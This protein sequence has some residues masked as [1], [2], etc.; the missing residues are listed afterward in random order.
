MEPTIQRFVLRHSW[1]ETL[2]LCALT[3]GSL[4]LYY[5]SLDVPKNIFNQAILGKGIAFPTEVAGLE[6]SQIG[7]LFLLCTWFLVLVVLNGGIKQYINT[8]KGRLGER[9]L[10]RM[11]YEL[12][13]RIMR[14]PLPHFRKVSSGELIPMVTAE[15]EPL[16]GYMGDAFAQPLIQAGTLLTIVTFLF[17]QN[18]IM[19]LAAISLYPV[20]GYIIPKLQR[21][22]NLLGK[23]RVR[24]VRKV[25]E[26]I[27][28]AVAGI[29]EIRGHGAVA[30]ERA[31]FSDRLGLIF[32]IRFEIYQRKSLAK[33]LNNFLNQMAPLLFYSIGGYLVITGDL[34]AGA[35]AAALTAHKDMSSPWKELLDYY[36]QYQ[37]T[38]IKF[39]QVVEQFRPERMVEEE[40]QAPINE[41]APR[42]SGPLSVANA[43]IAE[44]GHIKLLDG[45]SF[46]VKPGEK[47]ALCGP[48]GGGREV[49][50][51]LIARLLPPDGGRVLIGD[52]DYS[53]VPEVAL[54]AH[55]GYVGPNVYLFAGTLRD[56][57]AFGLRQR[58]IAPAVREP[59]A[60]RQH[61]RWMAETLRAG[62]LA[63]DPHAD[64]IDYEAA[65]VQDRA[66]F[67]QRMIALLSAVDMEDDVYQLGLRGTIDPKQ[68]PE[69]AENILRAR[70]ALAERLVAASADPS[71]RTLVEP[72]H[73]E[74]YN[75]NA[76]L[77]ENLLFGTPVNSRF[78]ID[79][80]ATNPHVLAVLDRLGLTADLMAAGR[81]VAAT[82]VELFADLPPGHEFFEQFSFISSDDLPEFRAMLTRVGADLQAAPPEDK[83]RLLG[84]P[85]KLIA[86]RHRLDVL[87]ERLKARIVEARKALRDGLPAEARAAIEF[88]DPAAYNAAA[89]LQD[90]ILFGKVAYGQARAA[91]RVGRLIAEVLDA[92][93]LRSAVLE[94]GLDF[95]VGI[96]GSRLTAAQRQKVGLARALIKRPDLVVINEA[97]ALLESQSQARVMEGV[98]RECQ[99]R[100][101]IWAL[102][103]AA[104]A[105]RFDR[106]LVFADGKLAEH[107][108]ADELERAGTLFAELIAAA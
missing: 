14:F 30:H 25:S 67:T 55:M 60:E 5:L 74:R 63:L 15:V 51:M 49:A 21:R 24:A 16:G 20:Q 44:D 77:A 99:G 39:E 31:D 73:P 93:H 68:R 2:I 3:I 72:F 10:R 37:D 106:V 94:V 7:Y 1:R 59:A 22:V 81:E 82:M 108:G 70:K 91:Q 17:V 89:T 76:T 71:M 19:G 23:D 104:L 12:I 84:L 36:Q 69:I 97:T 34:T 103:N 78:D 46:S 33:F 6:L 45:V 28:E 26:R 57:V 27:G 48:A 58:P 54:G 80:L 52:Q 102:H 13:A 107:G 32:R 105:R 62:N 98:F 90:N 85:F 64:W 100:I 88:F 9:L 75:N 18:P 35:L 43:T 38:K 92:L 4:P 29:H 50:A 95:P 87:D 66:E 41:R 86:A 8:Y 83:A 101:L 11:R 61:R 53:M 96:A 79:N 56:N 65:G 40:L 47:V 42:L